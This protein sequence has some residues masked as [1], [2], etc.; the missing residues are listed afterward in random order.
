MPARERWGGS[1]ELTDEQINDLAQAIVD[2]VRE[3]G[4]FMSMSDFVNRRPT[5]A[6]NSRLGLLE[7]A[8][9]RS[10][11]NKELYQT[12]SPG[13]SEINSSPPGKHF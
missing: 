7:E 9:Y 11:I 4:P 10:G 5:E 1:V 13:G 8:I 6:G 2:E 12:S 3:R